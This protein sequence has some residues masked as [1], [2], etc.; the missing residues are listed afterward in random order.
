MGEGGEAIHDTI[1]AVDLPC[2]SLLC[3]QRTDSDLR[4]GS[5]WAGFSWVFDISS[6]F[7]FGILVFLEIGPSPLY[8]GLIPPPLVGGGNCHVYTCPWLFFLLS[9]L[10]KVMLCN[11]NANEINVHHGVFGVVGGVCRVPGVEWSI[12]GW[13]AVAG[14]R[15][16]IGCLP[17]RLIIDVSVRLS[18]HAPRS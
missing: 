18:I 17:R 10:F 4:V 2:P 5:D 16:D 8:P 6:G 7:C 15:V 11:A 3:S 14:R 9:S 13:G 12:D 1:S